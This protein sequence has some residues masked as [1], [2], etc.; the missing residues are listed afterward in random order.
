MSLVVILRFPYSMGTK[1]YQLIDMASSPTARAAATGDHGPMYVTVDNPIKHRHDKSKR[2]SL[3]SGLDNAIVKEDIDPT[4]LGSIP[5]TD[6]NFGSHTSCLLDLSSY[7]YPVSNSNEAFRGC[8]RV[9]FRELT[10]VRLCLACNSLT[11]PPLPV[12]VGT[13]HTFVHRLPTD[14]FDA[15]AAANLNRFSICN[16]EISSKDVLL[17]IFVR[18][19]DD[20]PSSV[21]YAL[22]S[23]DCVL[24]RKLQRP[25]PVLVVYVYPSSPKQQSVKALE[26]LISSSSQRRSS[27][28]ELMGLSAF[29]ELPVLN[30][31]S[32]VLP[33]SVF[34]V[35]AITIID[36]I[37][38][39]NRCSDGPEA[40]ENL[41]VMQRVR[42]E[43]DSNHRF[44]ENGHQKNDLEQAGIMPSKLFIDFEHA[45]S[46]TS[47]LDHQELYLPEFACFCG[48]Q[49]L[50]KKA[51]Y[52]WD[53]CGNNLQIRNRLVRDFY[54]LQALYDVLAIVMV[55][56]NSPPHCLETKFSTLK[57]QTENEFQF[58]Y[59]ENKLLKAEN[60]RLKL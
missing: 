52:V 19:S 5:S 56:F 54:Q 15:K 40:H 46:E 20:S 51:D 6:N 26:S 14:R 59:N 24:T 35:P 34:I 39:R 41:Q 11:P 28:L 2:L 3:G 48:I 50:Q 53:G 22:V 7:R 27:S 23:R 18:L 16:A 49:S 42:Y 13:A 45:S 31:E 33:A 21:V 17:G 37:D 32:M 43:D 10:S 8:V 30:T 29:T 1:E 55:Q 12:S 9:H 57:D 58:L 44:M 36:L 38:S 25:Y 47:N 4:F 60:S